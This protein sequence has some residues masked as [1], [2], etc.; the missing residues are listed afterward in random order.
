[1]RKCKSKSLT[2]ICEALLIRNSGVL[3]YRGFLKKGSIRPQS[4]MFSGKIYFSGSQKE[5]LHFESGRDFM[6]FVSVD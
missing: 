3:A 4:N 5:G 2:K 6:N 1:M